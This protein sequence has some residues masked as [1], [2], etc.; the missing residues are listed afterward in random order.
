MTTNKTRPYIHQPWMYINVKSDLNSLDEHSTLKYH[1]ELLQFSEWASITNEERKMREDLVE[2]LK[3]IIL[4][5]Y[6]DAK[7]RI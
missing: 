4:S 5:I 6:P 3:N 2:R 7:V 1:N